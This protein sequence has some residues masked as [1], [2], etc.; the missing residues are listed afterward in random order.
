MGM[1]EIMKKVSIG[2]AVLGI[3]TA[4]VLAVINAAWDVKLASTGN[5]DATVQEE[6][7]EVEDEIYFFD[8]SDWYTLNGERKG[9]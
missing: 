3:A 7:K 8:G 5:Q 2:A 1:K 9:E 6:I 4:L